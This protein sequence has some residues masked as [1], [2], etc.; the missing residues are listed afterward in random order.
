MSW[1]AYWLGE[2]QRLSLLSLFAAALTVVA[3]YLVQY[4]LSAL[5]QGEGKPSPPSELLQEDEGSLFAWLLSLNSWRSEWQKAWIAALNREA[6]LR[7]VMDSPDSTLFTFEE[8]VAPQPLE[9][10]VQHIINVVKSADEKVVSCNVIGNAFHFIVSVSQT[11]PVSSSVASKCQSYRVKLSPLYLQLK[12]SVKS[13]EENVQVEWSF[14]YTSE[15]KTEVKPTEVQEIAGTCAVSDT[16]TS[17]LQNIINSASPSV[18]LSTKSTDVKAIQNVQN[19]GALPQGTSPPKP[20][21]A[22]E[23]KLLMKNIKASLTNFTAGS[24]HPICII[25]LNDP[26]QKFSSSVTNNPMDFS[27]KDEF[28]FELSAKSKELQV[29]IVENGELDSGFSAFATV[30]LDLFRKQPSGYRSFAL[31]RQH[32]SSSSTVGSVVAEFLYVDPSESRSLQAPAKL[33]VA[34][35]E[36]DRTVMPCGTVVTTVTAV[37]AKHLIEGRASILHSDSPMRSP[38]KMKIIEKD[39]S[40]QAIHCQNASVSKILSSSDTELLVLNG[41]DPVADIAIRQLSESAKQKL[42]SPRK[43]STIIISGVSKTNLSQDSEAVLMMDYAAAMDGS[44]K[45]DN[46]SSVE[47][48]VAQ[49]P[50]NEKLSPYVSQTISANEDPQENSHDAW[51]LDDSSQ[52]WHS[53]ALLDQDCDKMSGNSISI[54]ESGTVKKP[55]GGILKKSAKLFFLRRHH[56]KDPGMSQSHNDLIYLQQSPSDGTRKKGGTLTRILNKKILFKSKSKL[57]GTSVEPY[58]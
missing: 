21:R 26:L 7:E 52:Q 47:G 46:S 36:K 42:K 39:L 10:V 2:V 9:L 57:N 11:S 44:Y 1:L 45:Q 32:G 5:R 34:K 50:S 35:V 18:I 27:W 58:A 25:Q 3:V 48:S 54:S 37:K 38:A 33:P 56:Q 51:T 22:H 28:I 20:P 29:K 6:K 12:L 16:L 55:K 41:I 23:L 31:N 17:V 49:S 53:N 24:V 30:P 14:I 19:T 8:D 15:T 13:Q 43:K 4:G 40:I